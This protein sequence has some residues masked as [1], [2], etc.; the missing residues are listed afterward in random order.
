MSVNSHTL[1]VTKHLYEFLQKACVERRSELF[2]VDAICLNQ[3]D[4]RESSHQVTMMAIIYGCA[5]E[6]I[7]WL[8]DVHSQPC[9]YDTSRHKSGPYD[10]PTVRPLTTMQLTQVL[11]S[12]YWLRLWT[13][14]EIAVAKTISIQTATAEAS[15]DDVVKVFP[16]STRVI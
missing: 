11:S 4:V 13:I 3:A 12:P 9:Q 8:G 10:I 16:K 7:A 6:V 15:F 1:T 5:T 14:Q 2:W